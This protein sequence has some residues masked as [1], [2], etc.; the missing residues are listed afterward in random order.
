MKTMTD[1][2]TRSNETQKQMPN[3]DPNNQYCNVL[4]FDNSKRSCW[5]N[6]RRKFYYQ[7]IANLTTKYGSTALR[8]G[9]TWH[10]GLEAFYAHI[11]EHG[12][13]KDGSA[14]TVAVQAMQAA[15]AEESEGRNFYND[16]RTLENCIRAFVQYCNHF[17]MDELLLEVVDVEQDFRILMDVA[18]EE[19]RKQFPDLKP[20][21]FTG[22][23]DLKVRIDGRKWIMEHKS[24][25][26]SCQQVSSRLH[27]SAQVMGYNYAENMIDGTSEDRA[28]GI[29]VTIHSLSAYK[30]KVTGTYG[31]PKI[32]F[33]RAPQIFSDNDLRQWRISFLSAA[34]DVQRAID[35]HS[36]PM[37]H[38]SCFDF[39]VCPFIQL[40][41]Q[42]PD[43][44][45]LHLTDNFVVNST[46]WNPGAD[47]EVTCG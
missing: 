27:R 6:C 30:S 1:T 42:S 34:Q 15:F 14:M 24:T 20:F 5:M 4:S 8:Y 28:E 19:E 44:D 36:Y 40:C 12:W 29:L 18:T 9:T 3:T 41:E 31:D 35:N 43:I 13:T 47:V 10:A 26:M 21:H 37:N 45:H 46:I 22:K 33:L 11:K 2:L 38:D 7:Y 25:G 17:A 16:Y 39:G 23:R 32:D